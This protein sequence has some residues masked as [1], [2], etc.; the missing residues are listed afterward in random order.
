MEV[1][2]VG[3]KLISSV[4]LSVELK[5]VEGECETDGLTDLVKSFV[6]DTV[7]LLSSVAE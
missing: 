4:G 1:D 5:L 2:W 3:D 7:A 6:Q